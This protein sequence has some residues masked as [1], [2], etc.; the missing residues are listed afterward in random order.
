MPTIS[1]APPAW[2][3]ADWNAL[4]A[5]GL[6]YVQRYAHDLWTDYN[7]HDPGITILELLCYAIT[8]LSQRT[9]LDMK[10]LLASSFGSASAAQASFLTAAQVL[11]TEPVT[12]LDY[13]K[14]FI[15]IAGVRNAWLA[16][17]NLPIAVHPLEADKHQR[18]RYGSGS[19]LDFELRG[20][21][22]ITVDLDPFFIEKEVADGHAATEGA[23]R[24]AALSRVREAYLSHRNL[25]E[26][27]LTIS[28]VP[29]QRV[30]LCADVDLAPDAVVSEVYAR[31]LR[32]VEA[33][34]AP[35]VK[36]Y[37]LAEMR[38]QTD[39]N[40]QPLTIDQNFEGPLLTHGFVLDAELEKSTLR[41]T[42]YT[43]DLVNLI[44][45]IPGV[46]GLKKVRL[47]S[48]IEEAGKPCREWKTDD[49][50]GHRWCLHVAPGHQP[51]LCAE[52]VAL[53]FY[54][55]IIPVGSLGDKTRALQRLKELQLTAS[56]A[57]AKRV[58]DLPVPVGTVF[59]LAAYRS[60]ANDFPENYGIGP[61]GLPAS[62][63]VERQSQARQ[64]KAYLLF[65]DQL[66]TNYLA[67]LNHLKDLFGTDAATPQ[68]YFGQVIK[69]GDMAGVAELYDT[70]AALPD[71]LTAVLAGQEGYALDPS[72]KN[73]F[74]DHLL[75]RFAENFSEYGLLMHALYGARSGTEVLRDKAAL[76]AD[77]KHLHPARAYH[78]C[79][80][81]WQTDNV[82]GITRRFARL[83]GMDDFQAH[84]VAALTVL[85][86]GPA[87]ADAT[88][89]SF[90][91]H[92]ATDPAAGPPAPVY[93]ESTT[94]YADQPAAE[95][96]LRQAF[97]PVPDREAW[98]IIDAG[99]GTFT[100]VLHDAAG[101][102]E[103]ARCPRTF[104]TKAAAETDLEAALRTLIYGGEAVFVVEH[105]LLRPDA[106]APLPPDPAAESWLSVC[107]EP[108]GTF[109]EPLD[110]YSFRVSVVLPGYTARFRNVD[111]RRY[112]ERLLR[113]EMPAHILA[114][115]CWVGRTELLEFEQKYQAWLTEKAAACAVKAIPAYATAQRELIITLEKLFTIYPPGV[116]HDCDNADEENPIVL[117]RSTLG[118]L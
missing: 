33:Y 21:Y 104:P 51:Q 90:F 9:S 52:R 39:A 35:P 56:Q 99:S 83:A 101:T 16:A 111:F 110:P 36:R 57:N 74:L 53:A 42:I 68:T 13:R 72:R 61:I 46:V 28:E 78:Y 67:Q 77:Y 15:D 109:C 108:D 18:L 69:S 22:D 65:F 113:L 63:S 88:K 27:Y 32:A 98:A 38:A 70:Y 37:S 107:A 41:Q 11:P 25:C 24:A 105:L 43:S 40:G 106:A 66:L 50:A 81:A 62:A 23:A 44:M 64:L 102:A 7:R 60:V 20:L 114:R 112:A 118:S 91:L 103:L 30:M 31:I 10:D 97:H 92:A 12:E 84:A 17:H 82:A 86:T 58:D 96:A 89:F 3:A 48:L 95:K 79:R 49:A 47:N 93:L 94:A 5:V 2:K 19:A 26:D 71:K 116:L 87:P 76:L 85:D 34:L 45:A 6:K 59:D 14:L 117:G 80:P 73:R 4:R 1:A 29:I 75:A 54:K 115:I 55:D 100:Y 8:D